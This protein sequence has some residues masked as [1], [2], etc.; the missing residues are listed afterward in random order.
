LIAI[1]STT[2]CPVLKRAD[3]QLVLLIMISVLPGL[4]L[5]GCSEKH[6]MSPSDSA[7][8][9]GGVDASATALQIDSAIGTGGVDASVAALQIDDV[10]P[11]GDIQ[12]GS[13]VVALGRNFGVS[14]NS[15]DVFIGGKSIP[16]E[17][18]LTGKS[19]DTSLSFIVPSI[20]ALSSGGTDLSLKI[21]N[22]RTSGTVIRHFTPRPTV[23]MGNVYVDYLGVDTTTVS[24]GQHLNVSLRIQ[25]KATGAALFTLTPHLSPPAL[26]DAQWTIRVLSN[27]QALS[28]DQIQLVP[29][30]PVPITLDVSIPDS[31]SGTFYAGLSANSGIV[32]GT[33]GLLDFTIGQ[34]VRQHDS[35]I[36]I[37]YMAFRTDQ[38]GSI[39]FQ[40]DTLSIP[41]SYVG[42]NSGAILRFDVTISATGN[43]SV[44]A[45]VTSASGWMAA[46]YSSTIPT[47][48]AVAG[49]PTLYS[50][51][52]Y[53]LAGLSAVTSGYVRLIV[54]NTA[55]GGYQSRVFAVQLVD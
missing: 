33:S 54:K 24:A 51:E 15:V 40:S 2:V 23:T 1:M 45:D 19:S 20:D 46:E 6:G 21:S 11:A 28:G 47:P 30:V 36:A 4:S 52:Y 22:R 38:P 27:G 10:L 26:L 7:I 18:L 42:S 29:N 13:T 35:T 8:G 50:V 37:D 55:T 49:S 43:Y 48:P 39:L 9:P 53:V 41:R 32:T 25:S 31:A 3:Q 12:V 44:E 17:N 5:V 16:M 34:P 14:T